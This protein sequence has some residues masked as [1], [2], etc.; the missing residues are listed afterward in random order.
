MVAVADVNTCADAGVAHI[1]SEATS[2]AQNN[3]CLLNMV[4]PFP[5]RGRFRVGVNASCFTFAKF[6][7][8]AAGIGFN[9][10]FEGGRLTDGAARRQEY[11]ASGIVSPI[12]SSE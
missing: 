7:A 2:A 6:S 3:R 12:Q 9:K 4:T 11:A 10:E 5:L 1:A 8:L